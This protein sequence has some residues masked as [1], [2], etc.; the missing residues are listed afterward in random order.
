MRA[1]VGDVFP[2]DLGLPELETLVAAQKRLRQAST[3]GD[4]AAVT[5]ASTARDEA[6]DALEALDRANALRDAIELDALE[7]CAR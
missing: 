2:R 1:D 5:R 6:E 7:A 3:T 4:A